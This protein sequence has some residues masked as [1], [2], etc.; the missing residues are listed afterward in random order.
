MVEN[1][2]AYID[3]FDP[4]TDEELFGETEETE[5]WYEYEEME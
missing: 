2:D 4:L 5:G 1:F 3:L